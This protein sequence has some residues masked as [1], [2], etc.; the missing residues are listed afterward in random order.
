MPLSLWELRAQLML[1]RPLPFT[2]DVLYLLPPSSSLPALLHFSWNFSLSIPR[3][4]K[5]CL[6]GGWRLEECAAWYSYTKESEV[7]LHRGDIRYNSLFKIQNL[8]ESLLSAKSFSSLS[9][10]IQWLAFKI[11]SFM[12]NYPLVWLIVS[13]WK[14]LWNCC[15][16]RIGSTVHGPNW[17][18]ND[19]LE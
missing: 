10:I 11:N 2:R 12:I 15:S 14:A 4:S 3:L 13:I 1:A 5:M 9:V 8:H 16:H 18:A 6:Y 17:T 19:G 7:R